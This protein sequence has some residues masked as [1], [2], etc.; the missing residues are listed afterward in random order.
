[1]LILTEKTYRQIFDII[2]LSFRKRIAL[3]ILE[4]YLFINIVHR[5]KKLKIET[6]KEKITLKDIINWAVKLLSSTGFVAEVY[7]I[8]KESVF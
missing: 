5:M 6:Q 8:L 2:R 7:R 3:L 1:M 4:H